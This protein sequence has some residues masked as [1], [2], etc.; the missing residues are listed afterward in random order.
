MRANGRF[1][2]SC[3]FGHGELL[4]WTKLYYN[5]QRPEWN[6]M[7]GECWGRVWK[8]LMVG[9]SWFVV[10][11]RIFLGVMGYTKAEEAVIAGVAAIGTLK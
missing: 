4:S 10:V 2:L 9:G 11:V 6:R 3:E 8:S 7:T 1:I 5:F